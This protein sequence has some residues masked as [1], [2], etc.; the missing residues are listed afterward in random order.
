MIDIIIL[1]SSSKGS[2]SYIIPTLI[3]SDQINISAII[4]TKSK[5]KNK[6][7]FFIRKIK[8]IFQIGFFGSLIGIIMR[9]WYSEKVLEIEE[10][11][12]L[13]E[14][15]FKYSIPLIKTS[16]LNSNDTINAIRNS[17]AKLGVSLGN[18][19]ISKRVFTIPALGFINI[20]HELLPEYKNA[21]SIIWQI[22][23]KS[24]VS[25]YTIHQIDSLIDNGKILYKQEIPI[26]FTKTLSNTVAV[27]YLELRKKSADGLLEVLKDFGLYKNNAKKQP[28]GSSYTTP[29]FKQFI[30]IYKNYIFLRNKAKHKIL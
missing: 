24:E 13:E 14:I 22:F 6:N 26:K 8:K 15:S 11:S 16:K 27:N 4:L 30:K 1:T 29:T 20:H 3:K 12:S 23:N 17:K 18:S 19:Y 21:Q 10:C 5:V 28:T 2:A 25:G 7:K 9:K